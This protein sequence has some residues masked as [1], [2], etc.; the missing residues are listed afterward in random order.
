MK[1]SFLLFAAIVMILSFSTNVMAQVT[2]TNDAKAEIV[3]AITLVKVN[4]LEFGKIATGI[5]DGGGTVIL[6]TAG[7]A[8]P[9][10]VGLVAGLTPRTAAS[11]NITGEALRAYT[12]TL[13]TN[14][15][16]ILKHTNNTDQMTVTNFLA[17]CGLASADGSSHSLPASGSEL[18]TV[19]ATL[20][21]AFEQLAGLYSTTF[22]VT[23]VYD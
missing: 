5:G 14:T 11:Y 21:V 2:E 9:S 12:L 17:R 23:V 3:K 13:P 1:K 18:I 22:D 6:S 15:A 7:V 8:S 4:A 19:G 10:V 20:N 16:V